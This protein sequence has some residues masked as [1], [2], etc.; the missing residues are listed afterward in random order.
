M[1]S[2]AAP[3]PAAVS[4]MGERPRRLASFEYFSDGSHSVVTAQNQRANS[5]DD[6]KV[7]HVAI[8]I[9]DQRRELPRQAAPESSGIGT[10]AAVGGCVLMGAYIAGG[11]LGLGAV[12]GTVVAYKARRPIWA[13]TKWGVGKTWNGLCHT[14]NFVKRHAGTA[15]KGVYKLGCSV[16]GGVQSA[17]ELVGN[18]V[19]AGGGVVES[20]GNLVVSAGTLVKRVSRN[21]PAVVGSL[22]T[23]AA[24]TLVLASKYFSTAQ[25]E[26]PQ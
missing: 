22:V 26:Q 11:P 9:M 10:Q 12:A 21:H 16:V 4:I 6:G 18:V 15:A 14:G 23:S 7:N 2:V 5:P 13:V 8:P 25:G 17:Q 3:G 20:A 1:A 24:T 19:E